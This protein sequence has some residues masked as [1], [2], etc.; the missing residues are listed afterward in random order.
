MK[1]KNRCS[2]NYLAGAFER[3]MAL[4]TGKGSADVPVSPPNVS[5]VGKLDAVP[6]KREG[7]VFG[8]SVFSGKT[9]MQLN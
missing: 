5:D 7:H 4:Y 9:Q 2:L 1:M 8:V 6:V 3:T